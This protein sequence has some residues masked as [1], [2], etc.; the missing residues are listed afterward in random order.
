MSESA[1]RNP[2]DPPNNDLGDVARRMAELGQRYLERTVGELDQLGALVARVPQGDEA[3]FKSIE[4]LSHRIRGSGAM[5]G[6]EL[7]SDVAG[8]IELLAADAVLGLHP[9]RSTLQ[10][11]FTALLRVLAF[12]LRSAQR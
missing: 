9:A 12:V 2:S 4:M 6:F 8:E 3:V 1:T 7:V 10:M 11:R 5:F